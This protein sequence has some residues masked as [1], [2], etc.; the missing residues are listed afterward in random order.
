MSEAVQTSETAPATVPIGSLDSVAA[1]RDARSKGLS[2]IPVETPKADPPAEP[3]PEK[4]AVEAEAQAEP[5]KDDADPASAAGRELAK[6]RNSLQERINQAVAKQRDAERRAEEL[7]AKL[8]EKERTAAPPAKA[9]A[10]KAEPAKPSGPPR[11]LLKDFEAKIGSDYAEYADAVVAWKDADDDWKSARAKEASIAQ[12][13]TRAREQAVASYFDRLDSYRASTPDFD[14]VVPASFSV[15]TEHMEE[16][17]L[18]S[19]NGPA[20]V[21]H[22]AQ[23]P[24]E[25][26]RIAALPP[27]L[28]LYEMGKLDASV[29]RPADAKPSGPSAAVVETK[30]PPPPKPVGSRSTTASTADPATINSVADWRR[31]RAEF[32]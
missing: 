6:K 21:Y 24:A 32:L 26:A 1:Y 7:A 4:P 8:A 30:A 14:A 13:R 15:P 25:T 12:E 18:T 9:D 27:G 17:I 22:L 19:A 28:Q 11:P 10:A 29:S 3:E 31:K 5:E 16:A 20:L 23:H 2:E